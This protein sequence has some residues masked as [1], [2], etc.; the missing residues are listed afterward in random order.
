MAFAEPFFLGRNRPT[1]LAV[2]VLVAL[3]RG[4][5]FEGGPE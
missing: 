5:W 3:Y 4:E 1:R 2:A